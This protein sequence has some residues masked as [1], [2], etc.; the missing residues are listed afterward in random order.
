MDV[1]ARRFKYTAHQAVQ[2]FGVEV[3][4]HDDQLKV[5]YDDPK[6]RFKEKFEIWHLCMPRDVAP[7]G[8]KSA[9]SNRKLMRFASVYLSPRTQRVLLEEGYEEQPY[10][11]TRFLRVGCRVFGKSPLEDVKSVIKKY[12]ELEESQNELTKKAAFPAV[13]T[14][15]DMTP[16]ELDLRAGG[17][18]VLSE[19]ALASNLPREWASNGRLNEVML[20][21]EEKKKEIDDA[22]F[23]TQLQSVSS[24]ERPMTAT[25]VIQRKNEQLRTFSNT[26]TQYMADFR[27][28]TERIFCLLY[29]A[30]KLPPHPPAWLFD[31][32]GDGDDAFEILAP[33][34]EYHGVLAKALE[35]GK[36]EGLME[37]LQVAA[38]MYKQTGNAEW[39][40][41][42]KAYECTRFMARVNNVPVECIRTKEEADMERQKRESAALQQMAAETDLK[43][44]Q[45]DATRAQMAVES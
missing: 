22:L 43:Q 38:Q 7:V 2:R 13:L 27:P 21:K 28:M 24:Q 6:R 41:Y 29:R 1:V 31:K 39:L 44:A 19:K 20:D 15:A 37:A 42:Y 23:V 17:V 3:L 8:N 10:L 45:A 40:D 16:E 5:A 14:T 4:E 12:L 34:V 11:F 30:G 32:V 33:E 36:Q 18:T 26:F 25:E 9:I 35:E